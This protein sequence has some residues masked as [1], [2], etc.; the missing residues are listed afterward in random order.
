MSIRFALSALAFCLALTFT[1]CDRLEDLITGNDRPH[2]P[3]TPPP[4]EIIG[5]ARTAPFELIFVGS[6]PYTLSDVVIDG[7]NLCADVAYSGGCAEHG[8]QLLIDEG[9]MKSNPPQANA[10]LLHQ[11]NG[12]ACEALI[13]RK[14]GFDL[15]P[16]KEYLR[17]MTGQQSGIV[18]LHVGNFK[19]SKTVTYTY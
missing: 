4:C 15:T 11:A 3:K 13:T 19:D 18:V 14:V 5:A 16:Y 10:Y 7:D 9:L 12:D 6:D 1:G 8:F 2:P 17:R